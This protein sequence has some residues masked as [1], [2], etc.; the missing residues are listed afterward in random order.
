MKTKKLAD[1]RDRIIA[2]R[3][4]RKTLDWIGDQIGVG[5]TSVKRFC[6]ENNIAKPGVARP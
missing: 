4:A 3:E 5:E 2:W 1:N 6:N